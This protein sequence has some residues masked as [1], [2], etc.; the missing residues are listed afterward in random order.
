MSN[1]KTLTEEELEEI[2]AGG[3]KPTKFRDRWEPRNAG[4]GYHDAEWKSFS[5]DRTEVPSSSQGELTEEELNNIY[6]GPIKPEDLPD[7]YYTDEN[8]EI[9]GR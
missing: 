1:E 6:G 4:Q 7:N 8:E 5:G 2:K 9:M 3:P